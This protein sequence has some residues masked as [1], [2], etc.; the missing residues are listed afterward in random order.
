[1]KTDI[2]Q[3]YFE[4]ELTVT[5]IEGTETW[6]VVIAFGKPCVQHIIFKDGRHETITPQDGLVTDF[7]SVPRFLW[8]YPRLSPIRWPTCYTCHDA[9][10]RRRRFDSG[11]ICTRKQSD[12]ILY[13]AIRAMGGGYA[14]AYPIWLGVRIGAWY[15][16]KFGTD[17]F[18]M[19]APRKRVKK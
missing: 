8:M 11:S 13:E 18:V 2:K 4:N 6:R 10:V 12:D 7:G 16:G 14:D 15:V 5:P 19:G 9:A 17:R 3:V 1:M